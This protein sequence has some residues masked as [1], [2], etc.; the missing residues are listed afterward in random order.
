MIDLCLPTLPIKVPGFHFPIFHLLKGMGGG[1]SVPAVQEVTATEVDESSGLHI[2]EMHLPSAGFGIF[3]VL[4]MASLLAGIWYCW[5]RRLR[6]QRSKGGRR[7]RYLPYQQTQ[8]PMSYLE[9]GNWHLQPPMAPNAIW[10]TSPPSNQF[11]SWADGF[12]GVSRCH[13]MQEMPPHFRRHPMGN[14]MPPGNALRAL[15]P[16][17]PAAHVLDDAVIV[18][19]VAADQALAEP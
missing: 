10:R 19:A 17:P 15:A 4:G 9:S 6:H 8:P 16:A 11:A 1:N 13:E 12:G 3:S 5:R 14:R 2:F 7:D 18:D